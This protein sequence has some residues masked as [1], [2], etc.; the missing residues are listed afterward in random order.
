M[1]KMF[2][3]P[4]LIPLQVPKN[5]DPKTIQKK[6]ISMFHISRDM[7]TNGGRLD[8]KAGRQ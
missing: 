4:Q 5:I 7:K 6:L 3:D 8:P 2:T 1:K